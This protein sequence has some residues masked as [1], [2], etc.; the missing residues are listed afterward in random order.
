VAGEEA[1]QPAPAKAEELPFTGLP[2]GL[3]FAGA[4][5]MFAAG[6]G[7]RRRGKQQ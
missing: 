7:L 4:G 5:L 1:G 2:L 3:V 6:I